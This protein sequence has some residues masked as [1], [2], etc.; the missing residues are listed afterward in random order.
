MNLNT[1]SYHEIARIGLELPLDMDVFAHSTINYQKRLLK[2]SRKHQ[3]VIEMARKG[4]Q[5]DDE[6]LTKL[7]LPPMPQMPQP[8]GETEKAEE[9]EETEVLEDV[10]EDTKEQ[11]KTE[12]GTQQMSWTPKDIE[13][14]MRLG[15]EWLGTNLADKY[16]TY[17][18]ND[19]EARGHYFESVST[20]NRKMIYVL[21][22]FLTGI[23]AFMSFLTIYGKVSGDAL[24]FLVG[25]IT[26]YIIISI[27]RL[28]FPS[29]ESPST[30][31]TET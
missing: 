27:Q 5:K 2:P 1:S 31:E 22:V 28:V 6:D 20:H 15:M 29:E 11:A 21:I 16:L 30:G 17:K 25:T 26:G 18:K 10:K 24:L 23:V 4:K 14:L 12:K 13:A 9:N 7:K 8:E 3:V 19:A